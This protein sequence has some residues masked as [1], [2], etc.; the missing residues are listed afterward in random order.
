[1][2]R[3]EDFAVYANNS[4][5]NIHFQLK[6]LIYSKCRHR[7]L[8]RPR[9]NL[10]CW[11]VQFRLQPKRLRT[12]FQYSRSVGD[13]YYCMTIVVQQTL[14]QPAFGVGIEG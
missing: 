7:R 13:E 12:V 8:W 3:Y 14:E 6:N 10:S 2:Q 11:T 1:M 9:H 4:I 5:K